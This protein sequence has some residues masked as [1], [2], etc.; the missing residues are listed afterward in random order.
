MQHREAAPACREAAPG[1]DAVSLRSLRLRHQPERRVAALSD[2]PASE[3]AADPDR[4][5]VETKRPAVKGVMLWCGEANDQALIARRRASASASTGLDFSTDRSCAVPAL[6]RC[7]W[8]EVLE[9]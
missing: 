4:T 8:G 1:D 5:R 3:L 2:V 6:V 7:G 9:R